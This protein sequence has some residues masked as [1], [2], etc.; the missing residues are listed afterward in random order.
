MFY[1]IFYALEDEYLI[2]IGDPVNMLALHLVFLQRINQAVNEFKEL[3]NN[4]PLPK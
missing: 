1:Y 2:N 4:H 3:H